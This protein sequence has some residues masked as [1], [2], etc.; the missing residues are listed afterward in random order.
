MDREKREMYE[1]AL[2]KILEN[3]LIILEDKSSAIEVIEVVKNNKLSMNM[4]S[5]YPELLNIKPSKVRNVVNAFIEVNLPLGILEKDPE[6]IE[7][8]NATRVER[9]AKMFRSEDLSYNI[10]E[11]FPDII[12]IGN[13]ENM[14]QILKIFDDRIINR[15]FFVNAGDVLAYSNAEELDKIMEIL[16]QE[17][18]LNLVLKREPEVLYSNSERVI[19]QI[20]DLFKDPKEKLGMQLVRQDLKLLSQTTR[21]RIVAILNVLERAGVSRIAVKTCPEI[22]YLNETKTIEFNISELKNRNIQKEQISKIPEILTKEIIVKE[23]EI[24]EY[25][26]D[27]EEFFFDVLDKFPKVILEADIENLKEFVKYIE[28]DVLPADILKIAPEILV[29]NTPNNVEKILDNLKAIGEENYY[30]EFPTILNI[31][32]PENITKIAQVFE[33]LNLPKSIYQ[34]SVSIFIEGDVQ[35]IKSIV[36]EIDSKQIGREIL[37]NSFILARGNPENITKIID[38]FESSENIN[39]GKELL[40]RSGTIL[41]QGD[42]GKIDDITKILEEYGFIDEGANVPASIYAKGN[43]MQMREIYEYMN[44]IGLL[45]GLKSSMTLFIRPIDNIKENVNLLIEHGLLEDFVDNVSVLG[46]SP[47]TVE[48]RI[49]YLESIGIKPSIPVL[50]LNNS[51][52]YNQFNITEREL[53][54][55]KEKPLSQTIIENKY[56]NY[57]Y[58]DAKFLNLEGLKAVNDTY[59][60]IEE[61]GVVNKNLEYVKKG[62]SYSVIKIK[63]NIHKIISNMSNYKNISFLDMTEMFTMAILGNKKVAEKE[64]ND[65]RESIKIREIE[66]LGDSHQQILEVPKIEVIESQEEIKEEP[67]EEVKSVSKEEILDA[68]EQTKM[69]DIFDDPDTVDGIDIDELDSIDDFD[70]YSGVR[71]EKLVFPEDEDDY[72]ELEKL[73][74]QIEMDL[75]SED[76]EEEFN[77]SDFHLEDEDRKEL[78]EKEKMIADMRAQISDMNKTLQTIRLK[79]EQEKLEQ[80]KA[81]LEK[82]IRAELEKEIGEKL[83]EIEEE[84]KNIESSKKELEERMSRQ[85]GIRLVDEEEEPS[86]VLE[87]ITLDREETTDVEEVEEEKL[88]IE[89]EKELEE[90]KTDKRPIIDSRIYEELVLEEEKEQEKIIDIT[91]IKQDETEKIAADSIDDYEDLKDEEPKIFFGLDDYGYFA[92]YT[93]SEDMTRL[94]KQLNTIYKQKKSQEEE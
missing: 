27:N 80:E 30:K 94:Q 55:V 18:L 42:A 86:L 54:R 40:K 36:E 34:T 49:I 24:A 38:K 92:K 87:D 85:R 19:K 41:A 26:N 22:L 20:I 81:E 70:K 75:G 4:F 57:I 69:S 15:K 59:K 53:S 61:L 1:K 90:T 89:L 21:V 8:T 91:Q 73:E 10:I 74:N 78:T 6:I 50:K 29:K 62:Y 12:A 82:Q 84:N 71:R 76:L 45:S 39:L 93:E 37:Q 46:L 51:D 67:K 52:F 3:E 9:N 79:K 32:T 65:I 83:K 47:Q 11:R 33:E 43:P 66:A 23:L 64:I 35:N 72:E 5:K 7:K 56:A 58:N 60:Q 13:D 16:D 25:I 48:S 68:D 2:E 63:E 88:E 17:D 77:K 31:Q 44:K 28:K 14:L